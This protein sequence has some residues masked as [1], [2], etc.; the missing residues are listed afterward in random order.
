MLKKIGLLVGLAV[1]AM[2]LTLLLPGD[3]LQYDLNAK[4]LETDGIISAK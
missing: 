4:D 2:A 3:T 1:G